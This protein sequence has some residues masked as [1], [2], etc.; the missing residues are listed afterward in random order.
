MSS[1]H[2]IQGLQIFVNQATKALRLRGK[3]WVVNCHYSIL[4][5]GGT[6]QFEML[7]GESRPI[8]VLK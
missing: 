4:D 8:V 3:I 7:L 6:L 2:L 1:E 5:H